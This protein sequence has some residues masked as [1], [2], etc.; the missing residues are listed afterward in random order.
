MSKAFD[1]LMVRLF[2]GNRTPWWSNLSRETRKSNLG[3]S[4]RFLVETLK[5]EMTDVK[6]YRGEGR[7]LY[8][9]SKSHHSS[10][11]GRFRHIGVEEKY[12]PLD[13]KEH[14]IDGA[15]HRGLVWVL[16]NPQNIR[17]T[18][19]EAVTLYVV[20]PG[21][22]PISA[23]LTDLFFPVLTAVWKIGV[24][25]VF[26]NGDTGEVWYVNPDFNKISLP[27]WLS[28]KKQPTKWDKEL[29]KLTDHNRKALDVLS[30]EASLARYQKS[31]TR[32]PGFGSVTGGL[33]EVLIDDFTKAAIMDYGNEWRLIE[34]GLL[35]RGLGYQAVKIVYNSQKHKNNESRN[36]TLRPAGRG[37]ESRVR[38]AMKERFAI[39]IDWGIDI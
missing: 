33:N 30:H 10:I 34:L 23:Q 11:D 4:A 25:V 26:V 19:L 5:E 36:K 29:E 37:V 27:E 14:L 1:Q 18:M 2:Q 12:N 7:Q 32:I 35:L 13:I 28:V 9:F 3:P 6:E 16:G 22:M 39:L 15:I 17:E 24:T 20:R 21:S 31:A 38:D 8:F